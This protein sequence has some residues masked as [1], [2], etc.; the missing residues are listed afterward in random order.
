VAVPLSKMTSP[1]VLARFPQERYGDAQLVRDVA[2]GDRE[3][4]GIIWDRYSRLV[5]G[6]LYGAV[7]PD[8]SAEDLLQEVF[9]GFF[10]GAPRIKDGTLLRS[11]LIGVAVRTAAVELRRRKVRRWVGLTSTGD[12]P[13]FPVLAADSEGR[14]SLR[15][16]YR[17]LDTLSNRRRMAFV[18]RHVEGLELLEIAAA[19][20]VSE[21]TVRRELS[22][23]EQ[24]LAALARR[25]PALADYLERSR[26]LKGAE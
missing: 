7:G 8:S 19:L 22:R 9:L 25:E 14:E 10:R 5:R 18:L 11:Y 15:A 4:F 21:S 6:V 17:V 20:T 16:L 26:S 12:V 24:Q 13:E 2:A 1:A 23:A 3:A